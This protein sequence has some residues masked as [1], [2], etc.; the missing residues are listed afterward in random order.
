[1]GTEGHATFSCSIFM[2]CRQERNRNK[3]K[4]KNLESNLGLN[5]GPYDI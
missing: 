3:G 5:P 1:M 4:L 2:M